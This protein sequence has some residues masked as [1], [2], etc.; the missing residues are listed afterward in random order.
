MKR[1]LN[2]IN[3]IA[4]HCSDSDIPAHDDIKVIDQWHKER[5]FISENAGEF[6]HVGYHYFIQSSGNVQFGR[7][8]NLV[9]A[10]VA[11]HNSNTIGICLHGKHPD[12][13]AQFDSLAFM[14]KILRHA[15]GDLIVLGHCDLDP[16]NKKH[17]PGFDV[18]KFKKDYSI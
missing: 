18:V 14:I 1:Q 7:S 3:T 12:K 11:G 2:Q 9:G 4:I 6:K 13:K 10:H 8:L 16:V 17:C 5:G 15:F